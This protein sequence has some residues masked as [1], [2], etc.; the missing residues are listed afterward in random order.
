MG[1]NIERRAALQASALGYFA[2][3]RVPAEV[4][5]IMGGCSGLIS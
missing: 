5:V 4:T 1:N 3:A 2:D